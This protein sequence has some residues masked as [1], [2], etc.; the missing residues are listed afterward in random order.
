MFITYYRIGAVD[1]ITPNTSSLLYILLTS[2]SSLSCIRFY[3]ASGRP[4]SSDDV[5]LLQHERAE[6]QTARVFGLL[7]REFHVVGV[8]V[9]HLERAFGFAWL[10][11]GRRGYKVI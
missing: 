5:H 8:N 2:N 9:G 4:L 10:V 11:C 3:G 7:P 6:R 1:R